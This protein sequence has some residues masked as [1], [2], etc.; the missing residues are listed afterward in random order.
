MHARVSATLARIEA[1]FS[2]LPIILPTADGN[3]IIAHGMAFTGE[4]PFEEL[5]AA[6]ANQLQDDVVDN[7]RHTWP[8]VSGRPLFASS[9][10][11]VAC[12]CLDGKPWC[13]IGQLRKRL[14]AASNTHGDI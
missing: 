1:D 9:A 4:A 2:G 12:W 5:V 10:S 11:G 8:E 13:A 14:E 6:V 3:S 7:L